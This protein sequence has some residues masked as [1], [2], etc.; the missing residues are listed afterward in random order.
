MPVNNLVLGFFFFGS[1]LAIN[2]FVA[3]CLV[4]PI[5]FV[6][7]SEVSSSLLRSK[8]IVIAFNPYNAVNIVV[9]VIT[10]YMLSPTAW[11]WGALARFFWAGLC[12]LG[13]LFTFFMLPESKGR[14]TA[15]MDFLFEKKIPVR[16]FK[17]TKVEL[18]E[19]DEVNGC[20]SLEDNL[21]PDHCNGPFVWRWF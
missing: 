14:T 20:P 8:S 21:S 6:L 12:V 10:P 18:S 11:N 9:G 2:G 13:C 15:E 17:K 16:E 1:L 7:V 4:L 19:V 5:T 3:N